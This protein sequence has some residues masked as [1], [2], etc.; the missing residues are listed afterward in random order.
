MKKVVKKFPSSDEFIMQHATKIVVGMFA[1]INKRDLLVYMMDHAQVKKTSLT[2]IIKN[3]LELLGGITYT[4]P[5]M[6]KRY[7]VV[8]GLDTTYA[9]KFKAYCLKTGQI[10]ELKVHKSRNPKDKTVRTSFCDIP[11]C[12]GDILYMKKPVKKPKFTK[13]DDKWIASETESVWWLDD[14]SKIEI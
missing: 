2:Q 12:N 5:T 8:I 1:D 4:D 10:A 14:Y 9:P 7:I 13:V 6:D 11:F 3:Q